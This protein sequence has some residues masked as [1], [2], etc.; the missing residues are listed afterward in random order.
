MNFSSFD[1]KIWRCGFLTLENWKI[2]FRKIFAAWQWNFVVTCEISQIQINCLYLESKNFSS[3]PITFLDVTMV[4]R[5]ISVCKMEIETIK[6]FLVDNFSKN[7]FFWR[8]FHI[9][10]FYKILI[11]AILLKLCAFVLQV[12]ATSVRQVV[13][14]EKF[15]L[16]FTTTI[17]SRT[18][19][20][21]VQAKIRRH[22]AESF[23][24]LYFWILCISKSL[25]SNF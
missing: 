5:N 17:F 4:P 25:L 10:Q 6:V 19:F 20:S 15:T 9:I 23:W 24:K 14:P 1:L 2:I 12:N 3:I 18:Q 11:V 13:L 8:F 22:A 7:S 16:S 21:Q